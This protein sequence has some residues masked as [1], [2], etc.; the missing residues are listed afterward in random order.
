MKKNELKVNMEI[1]MKLQWSFKKFYMVVIFREI[2]LI[3]KYIFRVILYCFKL[4]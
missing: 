2:L 3:D 4:L 1:I